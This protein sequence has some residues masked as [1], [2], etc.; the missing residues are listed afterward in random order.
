METQAMTPGAVT[1]RLEQA[2]VPLAASAV[3]STLEA[4]PAA[5]AEVGADTIVLKAGGLL[6]KTD[7]GGVVLNL[8]TAED[9]VAAAEDMLGRI[10][11][12]ALPFVL[13]E[14]ERGLEMLVGIQ[15]TPQLGAA[16]VVGMGGVHTEVHK[17][18]ARALVPVSADR[19]RDLLRELRCWPLLDGY[20][21]A[22]P[23]DVEALVNV[24]LR[25]SE[26]AEGD[27]AITELDLN[28]VLVRTKGDG[29]VVVDARMLSGGTDEAGPRP[30]P[31]LDRMLRPR[32]LAVVG[33]SDDEHKVGA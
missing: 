19:A 25:I 14:Q 33:V 16:L 22:A 8:T 12:H 11:E 27:P 21:G 30:S 15:R 7:E 23:H 18:V 3:A 1:Q 28:P 20:R 4:V 29:A 6:H 32:H 9:A 5:F 10:G 2:G 31:D 26:L 17:D 13:Q 24:M